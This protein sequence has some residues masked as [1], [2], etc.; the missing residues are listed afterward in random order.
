MPAG[1]ERYAELVA[2]RS[3]AWCRRPRTLAFEEAGAV[4]RAG[5]TA[6]QLL[7]DT[8]RQGGERV[9][10]HG[11]SGGAGG[12]AVQIAKAGGAHVIAPASATSHEYVPSL[13][14]D[15]VID[16]AAEDFVEVVRAAHPDGIEAVAD[17]VG[18]ETQARSIE[19]LQ[20]GRG[21]L[22]SI[23]SPPDRERFA[24]R[25][26]AAHYVFVRPDAAGLETLAT[27]VDAGDL[28]AHLHE[29]LA[30]EQAARAREQIDTRHT[31]GKMV[32]TP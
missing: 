4:P 19:V 25:G 2:A 14:A 27:L 7:R 9:L 15:N 13:G 24:A 12:F 8:L 30:L 6:P 11:A 18:G 16:Y 31:R 28:R 1:V 21:R 17:L 10:V 5:L 26:R 32:L 23:I 29:V 20:E 22:G 3:V